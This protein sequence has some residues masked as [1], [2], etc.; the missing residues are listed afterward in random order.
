MASVLWTAFFKNGIF[1]ATQRNGHLYGFQLLKYAARILKKFPIAVDFPEDITTDALTT[2]IETQL[3]FIQER[4]Q[5]A[6][7]TSGT[8]TNR[9]PKKVSKDKLAYLWQHRKSKAI[10][11]ILNN[12][13]FP[14][15]PPTVSD[16]SNV[17]DYYKVKCQT[18]PRAAAPLAPPP[19]YNSIDKIEVGYF[20]DTH[21]FTIEEVDSILSSLPNN[22]AS[23]SD[24][25]TYE[26][27]RATRPTSTQT[28]THIFNACLVNEKLPDSWEGALIHRIPKGEYSR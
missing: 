14:E 17:Y 4:I 9:Q 19:W 1:S 6:L 13:C 8:D 20:P 5:P 26:T 7:R 18:V 21:Q 12:S 27:L 15:T 3:S 11:I 22:K 25:V 10:N 16:T 23:G 28:L 24:G 2:W